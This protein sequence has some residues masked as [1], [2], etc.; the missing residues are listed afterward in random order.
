[1]TYVAQIS[2]DEPRRHTMSHVTSCDIVRSSLDIQHERESQQVFE[3]DKKLPRHRDIG[4]RRL[5]RRTTSYN[6]VQRRTT[7]YNVV[8]RR[9]TS[10]NVVQRRTTVETHNPSIFSFWNHWWQWTPTWSL[11]LL[12]PLVDDADVTIWCM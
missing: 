7:S 1:M 4:P 5:R 2:C 3:H 6:V 11:G 9:T 12:D 8:Q 10:Y